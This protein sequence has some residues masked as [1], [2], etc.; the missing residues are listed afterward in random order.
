MRIELDFLTD[1]AEKRAACQDYWLHDGD[2]FTYGVK[3]VAGRFGISVS[4]VAS[5]IEQ[6]CQAY[7]PDDSCRQCHSRFRVYSNRSEYAQAQLHPSNWICRTCQQENVAREQAEIQ[8]KY[9]QVREYYG[10]RSR[11]SV[12]FEDGASLSPDTLEQVIALVSLIRLGADEKIEYIQPANNYTPHNLAP[13]S[14]YE[15]ELLNSLIDNYIL[16]P[17]VDHSPLEAFMFKDGVYKGEYY[18]YNV[19]WNL[20]FAERA[21]DSSSDSMEPAKYLQDLEQNFLNMSWPKTWNDQW[22]PL[23]RRIALEECLQYLTICMTD[24]GFEFQPG[25]KTRQ[26]LSTALESF[27]VA[28]IY[29]FIWR[30]TK[31]AAAVLHARENSQSA[32]S[33]FCSGQCSAAGGKSSF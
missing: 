33:K 4:R 18:Y 12:C 22:I 19:A 32:G 9:K 10:R 11:G 26:V 15:D 6:W 23:W 13:T 3:E 17:N 29:N 24:H 2:K 25:S 31:D 20:P 28:Q 8:Q 30:G 27:S 7:S 21:T 14:E 16:F 1:E 5:E